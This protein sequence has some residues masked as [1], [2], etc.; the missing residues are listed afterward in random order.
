M[1]KL[2]VLFL[3]E[4]Q[5]VTIRFCLSRPLLGLKI[6]FSVGPIMVPSAVALAIDAKVVFSMDCRM[7]VAAINKLL[8]PRRS[9]IC[10][11]SALATV[12]VLPK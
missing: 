10:I 8:G 6:S 11:G 3:L 12:T 7:L 4:Y 5:V 1:P 2:S 9:A